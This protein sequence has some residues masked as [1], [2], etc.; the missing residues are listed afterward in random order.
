MISKRSGLL[1]SL[2]LPL[3]S[4]PAAENPVVKRTEIPKL[5][6]S[7]E[8]TATYAMSDAMSDEK[9]GNSSGEHSFTISK[10]FDK[11]W[12]NTLN[13]EVTL[14]LPKFFADV[15]LNFAEICGGNFYGCRR[16]SNFSKDKISIMQN[17]TFRN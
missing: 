2:L 13:N 16:F 11:C 15:L 3:V 17:K 7:K 6:E 9:K 10:Y 4:K 8:T 1:M 14:R 12:S 5:Y